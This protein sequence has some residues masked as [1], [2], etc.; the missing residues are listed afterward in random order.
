MEREREMEMIQRLTRV[1][2]KLD[3]QSEDIKELRHTVNALVQSL[4][5]RAKANGLQDV[6]I[7]QIDQRLKYVETQ[8]QHWGRRTWS[9][10]V[11]AIGAFGQAIIQWFLGR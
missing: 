1:E 4:N 5:E 10:F 8:M 2:E 9:A 11:A 7:A 3:A 6:S